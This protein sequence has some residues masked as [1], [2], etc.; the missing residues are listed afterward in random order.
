M[1]PLR[2]PVGFSAIARALTATVVNGT[3]MISALAPVDAR[4]EDAPPEPA[5]VYHVPTDPT[6]LL[7]IDEPMRRFFGERLTPRSNSADQ[8]RKL[9]DTILQPE[10]LHFTYDAQGTFDARET[11]RQRRGNCLSFSF[12]VV[13]VAREFGYNAS[14][15]NVTA[16][17]RWARFGDLIVSVS[18]INV[19]VEAG[20]EKYLI[21]LQ[22]ELVSGLGFAEMPL[23]GDER[24]FAQFYTAVGFFNLLHAQPADALQFMTLATKID[25][26]CA[27]AW[28]NLGSLHFHL[29]NL[30]EARACFERS[31]RTDSRCVFALDGFVMVLRRLGSKEDLRI[32]AKY[33]HRAQAI[34]DRNP[35]YQQRLAERAQAQNDWVTAEKLLR[36]A[37]ALKD[38]EPQFYEQLVKVLLQLGRE[39]DARRAAEKLE[40]LRRRLTTV[41]GHP[42]S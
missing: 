6:E 16:A 4:G 30:A 19:R 26:K 20:G 35:Y 2:P 23:V 14:F 36:R 3:L 28:A 39:D 32:A 12:L 5:A 42:A 7:K 22:P 15:Q 9:I 29:G 21:D 1:K 8:L 27:D 37:I 10:G 17:G 40:K 41:P 33:E 38:D 34:R 25:P 18:H 31:L 11:F 24:A 13:A